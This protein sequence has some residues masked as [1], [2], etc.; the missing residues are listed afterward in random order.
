MSDFERVIDKLRVDLARTPEERARAE[1][2]NA[3]KGHARKEI[4]IMVAFCAGMIVLLA[5][6]VSI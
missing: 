4:A 2:F 1:G 6:W 5:A 3:G